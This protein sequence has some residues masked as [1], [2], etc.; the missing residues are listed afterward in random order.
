MLKGRA[1]LLPLVTTTRDPS[2]TCG[3]FFL[4]RALRTELRMSLLAT[5]Y[6]QERQFVEAD[7]Q[8]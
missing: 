2:L 7:I 3:S 4:R 1:R 6:T 8:A 5:Y